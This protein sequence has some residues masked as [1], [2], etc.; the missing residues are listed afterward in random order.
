MST[1]RKTLQ[2]PMSL[3]TAI[4]KEL[5]LLVN[6]RAT[7]TAMGIMTLPYYFAA[8][9]LQQVLLLPLLLTTKDG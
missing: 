7:I 2:H 1:P 4:T 5:L 8:I 9:L 3:T 6:P